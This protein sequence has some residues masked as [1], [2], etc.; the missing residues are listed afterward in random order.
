MKAVVGDEAL[1][2]EDRLYLDFLIKFEQNYIT[3]GLYENR[4]IFRSLDLGW[5][6]LRLFPKELLK[7]IDPKVIAQYYSRERGLDEDASGLGF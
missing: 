6:L 2:N 5:D 4:T 1:T 7:R 3:Q